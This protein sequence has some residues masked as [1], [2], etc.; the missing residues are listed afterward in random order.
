MKKLRVAINGFGRIGR[1]STRVI[2]DNPNF[3]LVAVN[4]RSDADIYAHLLKYDSIYGPWEKEISFDD[5]KALI[6][7]GIT[8]PLYH[9]NELENA[10]WGGHDV[11][12]VIE[13]TAVFTNASACQS[14]LDAGAKYVVVSC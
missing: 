9:E 6:V 7:D 1:I 13:S 11:D 5:N 4:S 3:E 14:H 8:I 12:V 10:P 2:W